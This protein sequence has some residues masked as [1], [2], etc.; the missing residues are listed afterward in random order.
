MLHSMKL[1]DRNSGFIY[2][3]NRI[4]GHPPLKRRILMHTD[5]QISLPAFALRACSAGSLCYRSISMRS[6]SAGV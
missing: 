6:D 2:T 5:C 4:M 1:E 3:D